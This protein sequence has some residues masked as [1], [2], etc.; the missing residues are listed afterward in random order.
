M[1]YNSFLNRDYKS[2]LDTPDPV[3]HSG[4]GFIHVLILIVSLGVITSILLFMSADASA[5]KNSAR[6]LQTRSVETA[7]SETGR[8]TLPLPVPANGAPETAP[9]AATAARPAANT[10]SDA[11]VETEESD[12]GDWIQVRVKRGDALAHIFRR[13]QLSARE[14]HDIMLL[15]GDTRRLKKLRPGDELRLRLDGDGHLQQLVYPL[16]PQKSL[17]VQR[18][19]QGFAAFMQ[20]KNIETRTNY[21]IARIDS[22]LYEAG[23]QAGLSDTLIMKMVNIFGWDIDF[24]LDIRKGDQFA[25]IYEEQFLDGKKIGDGAILAAEFINQGRR[26]RALRFTDASGH[27]DYYTPEGLSMRKAFLRTPVDFRRIS[28]RFGRRHHPVLNKMRLHKG[29]DY[30]AKTG[31]PIRAA[32]DGK[33]IFRGRKGGYG[34]TVIIQHGG[35]YSTLYAHMSRFKKG[36]VAG[37]RV[38]QGQIIGYVGSSGRAT[39]PHLHYEFRVNG[40]HRNPLTIRLPNAAPI[41]KQYRDRFASV[42]SALI[43][44]LDMHRQTRLAMYQ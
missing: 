35:R 13:H 11:V 17:H 40:V 32:G 1:N 27:S 9:A 34:R 24:A 23:K 25:L 41:K 20:V 7:L 30:A 29:V 36:L 8:I 15:G 31:T 14:L 12:G 43:A 26:F 16:N 19:E 44:Q 33:I 22:S 38:R 4:L 28:S 10:A 6:Q 2:L 3:R 42:A 21:A 18:K 39:G 5:S 37:K